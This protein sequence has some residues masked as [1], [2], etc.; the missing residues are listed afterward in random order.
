MRLRWNIFSISSG[1]AERITTPNT[2]LELGSSLLFLERDLFPVWV[3]FAVD[4]ALLGQL[5]GWPNLFALDAFR[6]EFLRESSYPPTSLVRLVVRP[7]PE[8]EGDA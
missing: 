1:R 4:A 2:L 8:G 3:H 7:F 5:K 6:S